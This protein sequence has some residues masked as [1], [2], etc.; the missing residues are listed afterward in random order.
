MEILKSRK[1]WLLFIDFAAIVGGFVLRSYLPQYQDAIVLVVGAAQPIVMYLLAKFTID[2]T[3]T[4]IM[5][6]GLSK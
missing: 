3:V 1:F 4:K 5:L 2:D 6:K